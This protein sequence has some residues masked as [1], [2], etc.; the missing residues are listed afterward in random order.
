REAITHSQLKHPNI[1]PFLGIYDQNPIPVMIV[2]YMKGGS[3][4]TLL[5]SEKLLSADRIYNI[6][7]GVTNGLEYLHSLMVIHGD[8]NPANILV[9][10]SGHA[11]ICDFGLSRIRYDIDATLPMLPAPAGGKL[12]YMAPELVENDTPESSTTEKSDIFTLAMTFFALC[13]YSHPFT[14]V[15]ELEAMLLLQHGER[16]ANLKFAVAM[17]ESVKQILWKLI[18]EMWAHEPASRPSSGSILDR[19]TAIFEGK[20]ATLKQ[21]APADD[22]ALAVGKRKPWSWRSIHYSGR[23]LV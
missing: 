20:I 12:R 9:D 23:K 13:S 7:L 15:N 21:I 8:P 5:A 2:P 17:P 14:D 19:L 11:Y 4:Q 6:L 18:K 10:Q 1:L 22:V 16:P 3:L